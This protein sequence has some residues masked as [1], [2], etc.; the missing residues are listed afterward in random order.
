MSTNLSL[1]MMSEL[2][3]S[4]MNKFYQVSYGFPLNKGENKGIVEVGR[5]TGLITNGFHYPYNPNLII[6][7]KRFRK[8][9]TPAERYLWYKFLK[10][11]KPRFIRQRTVLHYILDF[12]CPFYKLCIELDGASHNTSQAKEYDKYRTYRLNCLGITV[13]RFRNGDVFNNLGRIIKVI[14]SLTQSSPYPL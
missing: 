11:C 3:E 8:K 1:C 2:Y 4:S 10:S 7:A 5:N 6:R 12:Y 13:V 9:M 14:E